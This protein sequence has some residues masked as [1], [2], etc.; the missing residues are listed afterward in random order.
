M[1]RGLLRLRRIPQIAVA[2]LLA[3]AGVP[4]AASPVPALAY[5]VSCP[6]VTLPGVDVS[7]FQGVIDWPSVAAAGERF[8]VVRVNDGFILDPMTAT[9]LA[10]ARAAGLEV[11]AYAFAQPAEDPIAEAQLFIAN[12]GLQPGDLRPVLDLEVTDGLGSTDVSDW[13]AAWTAVVGAYYGAPPIIYTSPGWWNGNVGS[14]AYGADPLWVANWG[15]NCPRLPVGWSSWAMWQ[16][17]DFGWVPG[18]PG[19]VDLDRFNGTSFAPYVLGPIPGTVLPLVW[20]ERT[21]G[22]ATDEGAMTRFRLGTFTP[23]PG[24]D[25]ARYRAT[26]SWGDGSAPAPVELVPEAGGVALY[27]E[28]AF[29]EAGGAWPEVRVTYAG[30]AAGSRH[31]PVSVHE[32]PLQVTGSDVASSSLSVDGVV[33]SI[34]DA[35]HFAE[36]S[37]YSVFVDWGDES[38]TGGK[39]GSSSSGATLTGGGGQYQVRGSHTYPAPGTYVVTVTVWDGSAEPVTV[40]STATAG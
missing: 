7:R 5:T 19:A 33:A 34:A 12:S 6:G 22:L 1:L 27:A 2:G 31:V 29:R 23:A 28:H 35:N 14:S 24:F 8:A 10:G 36:A 21:D 40:T 9:N 38:V 18:I 30:S 15:V 13:V 26:V 3:V 11:G 39:A 37:D 20:I 4:V 16:Y 17:S 32:V 25:A